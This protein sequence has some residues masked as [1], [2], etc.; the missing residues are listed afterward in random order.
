VSLP[1]DER[2]VSA[3]QTPG[4]VVGTDSIQ[5]LYLHG[6]P[7][8]AEG[9]ADYLVDPIDG[10]PAVAI[11]RPGFGESD[12]S[13]LATL[14][15]QSR[16]AAPF[17]E[18]HEGKTLVVGHSYG[19]PVALQIALDY[20]ERVVGA[21]ILA[22]S[23]APK[24]EKRRWFNYAAKGLSWVLPHALRRSNQEVWPLRAD[25]ERLS[26]R[27]DAIEI[28]VTVVHGTDDGLVP[29][30]NASFMMEAL[31]NADPLTLTTLQG[32]G[33]MIIWNDDEV[34]QVR[35]A[36]QATLESCREKMKN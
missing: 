4:S 21:V 24:L 12:S 16:A 13:S 9:W 28:P 20:P 22:G 32:A 10:L 25:L 8:D 34:P 7:G 3:L 15:G 23:V 11:D 30:G 2:Q 29:Y 36:I 19:G 31:T 18:A 1:A 6:T 26:K 33:H 14:E 27:L 17:L 5:I 35:K